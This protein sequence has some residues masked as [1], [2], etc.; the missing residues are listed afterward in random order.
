MAFQHRRL[1]LLSVGLVVLVL[2]L[3]G[4]YSTAAADAH[5]SAAEA[6]KGAPVAFQAE[7]SKMLD[8]LV[9]SLYTNR[10]IFL[11][12]LISNGSDALDKIRVMYLRA[13]KDPVSDKGEAPTMDIRI[14]TNES[15]KQI[16]IRDGGVGM[17][18]EELAEHLG[19]LGTSGTKK[20][21][22]QLQEQVA[23]GGGSGNNLIGQFGVGFYS[24]FLVAD[25]VRVASKSDNSPTQ[26]MW[27]STGNGQYFLYEDA[28]GNTLGRGTEITI[29][30]KPDAVEF[31]N[32]DKVKQVIHQYSE[33]INFPI[34]LLEEKP[35]TAAKPKPATGEDDA[36][37]APETESK[38]KEYT[39]K[40]VN[41][42]KPIWTRPIGEVTEAEYDSFYKSLS[43]DYQSPMYYSHFR[44]EGEIEFDSILFIPQEPSM[45]MFMDES[46]ISNNIKL[47]VRRVFITDEFRDLLPRYLNFIRG[48]V[49]SND[50]PLN[51]SRE[52]LQEN[53]ILRVIKKK[54]IRKALLMLSDIA[55]Q[56]E[57]LAELN[58]TG[59]S[60]DT[61]TSQP[62]T[63]RLTEPTY[64]KFWKQ[65]GKHIRFGVINDSNNRGR[66]TKLLRYK[67]SKSAGQYVSLET[68][69]SRMQP[70][71]KGI[72]Y[73]SGDT[74]SKIKQSPM[75]Q[76]A[77]KRDIEVIFMTDAIDEYVVA[78]VPDFSGKKLIN[79]AKEGVQF[80]DTDPR[81][82]AIMKKRE[83]RYASFLSALRGIL[84]YR[85]VKKVVLTSRYTTEAFILSSGEHHMTARLA[86]IVR[87]QAMGYE[88]VPIRTDRVLE[89]NYRHPLV[90]EMFRRLAVDEND[91]V[92]IDLAWVLYDTASLQGEFPI[93]NVAAYAQRM[94][95]LLRSSVDIAADDSLLPA[96]D[97]EYIQAIEEDE[98]KK[99][100]GKDAGE[101]K[102]AAEGASAPDDGRVYITEED[103]AAYEND[104]DDL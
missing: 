85:E 97:E 17:T 4:A 7:V 1:P 66:L 30:L 58:A 10:A 38:P 15:T 20:F 70:G 47:Y 90:D 52:V 81:Q 37:E 64:N 61:H 104:E 39:W 26:Y 18:K 53:R 96:D 44:V 5:S 72:Y 71:Q 2:V 29:D 89:V 42:N 14:S 69:Q 75:L 98:R 23:A 87:G 34:Y 3:A 73:L 62:G 46:A 63:K 57:R 103:L 51:V 83:E 84:G 25:R 13:R 101:V 28:R 45:D 50:L 11:R 24:V 22:E 48:V 102:E 59:K 6:N 9:N 91:S 43:K 67:S 80:D 94:N 99:A 21:L 68:Y 32:S 33:F 49:D 35:E 36:I 60:I 76:D 79:L 40:V 41:E 16:V 27:E 92:A 86:N 8:I 55:A 31:S 56:D 88:S 78:Q 74:V 12:E 65:F 95:R 77:M 82:G 19:S 100:E 54:L 93:K